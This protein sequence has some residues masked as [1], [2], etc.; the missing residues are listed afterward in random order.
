MRAVL[1]AHFGESDT[2]SL[3]NAGTT[4]WQNGFQTLIGCEDYLGILINNAGILRTLEILVWTVFGGVW[5]NFAKY[6]ILLSKRHIANFAR[7]LK[8]D[9]RALW[10]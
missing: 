9:S 4:T 1:S 7:E 3:K 6:S 2:G 10:L 5:K 8:E